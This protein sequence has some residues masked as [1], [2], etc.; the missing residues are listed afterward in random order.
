MLKQ[1][2]KHFFRLKG[3]DLSSKDQNN[4]K[5]IF[6]DIIKK[7]QDD[8]PLLDEVNNTLNTISELEDQAT[9]VAH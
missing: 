9:I 4:I 8:K 2:F 3:N 1:K 5:I 6:Q 7:Q